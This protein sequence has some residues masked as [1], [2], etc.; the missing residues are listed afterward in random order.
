MGDD[1][2]AAR[3]KRLND[4][5]IACTRCARLVAHREEIARKKRRAYRE[6]SYWGRAVPGFGDASARVLILGL[7]PGA[8]G[9]NRTGRMFTGDRSGEWLYRAL[10]R[11]GFA[12]QAE[13]TGCGDGLKL[14]DAYITNAVRCVPPNNQP[15]RVEIDSCQ[16]YLDRELDLLRR[17]KAIV[18]LGHVGFRSALKVLVAR[19]AHI[20][21]PR[22]RF[23]HGAV[24]TLGSEQ[25]TV[26]CS[27]HP[28]Q[29]NTQTG[30]LTEQMLDDV[31]REVRRC[32][33]NGP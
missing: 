27:Y 19:G 18:A 28:S 4:E 33:L 11:A 5:I 7:A 31:F 13:S 32:L 17:V 30:R 20:G 14:L 10:H 12:S 8:H 2:S 24:I 9:A 25:P 3:F 1:R 22:P 6:H 26:I 16:P 23:G 15:N 21:R 29:Q